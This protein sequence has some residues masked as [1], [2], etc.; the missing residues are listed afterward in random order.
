MI[1]PCQIGGLFAVRYIEMARHEAT[2][3][4][5]KVDRIDEA[6]DIR[7]HWT[8]DGRRTVCGIEIGHRQSASGNRPCRRC[9]IVVA[10]TS[11]E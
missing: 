7:E 6:G 11:G 2:G 5:A 4:L 8:R 10:A 9:Q 1:S 3:V